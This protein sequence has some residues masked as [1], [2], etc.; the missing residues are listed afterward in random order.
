VLIQVRDVRPRVTLW[1]EGSP[2]GGATGWDAVPRVAFLPGCTTDWL[3]LPDPVDAEPAVVVPGTAAGAVVCTVGAG[4]DGVL[5]TGGGVG[6]GAGGG[7]TGT[8]GKDEVTERIDVTDVMDGTVGTGNPSASARPARRPAPSRLANA[9]AR[10]IP[11]QLR[12]ARSGCG[13]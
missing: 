9:A 10:R 2:P 3:G 11:P 5:V 1:P 7:G 12:T 8:D 13:V 6:G 4:N